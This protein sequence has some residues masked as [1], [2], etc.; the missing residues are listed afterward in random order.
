MD[1]VA[2][3]LLSIWIGD[4]AI[5]QA[6]RDERTL[7]YDDEQVVQVYQRGGLVLRRGGGGSSD[8]NTH[9]PWATAGGGGEIKSLKT[10]KFMH[11]PGGKRVVYWGVKKPKKDGDADEHTTIV[12]AYPVGTVFGEVLIDPKLGAFE[13]RTRKRTKNDWEM[14]LFR[15]KKLASQ[16]RRFIA[17]NYDGQ[18][19][20]GYQQVQSCTECH[21]DTGR[22]E[23]FLKQRLAGWE[24]KVRGSDGIFSWHPLQ[25]PKPGF[26]IAPTLDKRWES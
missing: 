6:L 10:I 15:P 21:A 8:P 7:W 4:P 24:G 12:W 9:R 25:A 22:D 19:P 20:A 1:K 14:Q 26:S 11:V 13:L 5:E 2:A 16:P 18:V 3:L 17:D 23:S